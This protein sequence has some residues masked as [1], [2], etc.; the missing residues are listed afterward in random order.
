MHQVASLEL[1]RPERNNKERNINNVAERKKC[2]Q[3]K[4]EKCS[5]LS[6]CG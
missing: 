1:R 5:V 4:I 3:Q 2:I 6:G